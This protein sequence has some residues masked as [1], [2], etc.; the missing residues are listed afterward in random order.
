MP[1]AWPGLEC[2]LANA[3]RLCVVASQGVHRQLLGLVTSRCSSRRR[4]KRWPHRL[5][6]LKGVSRTQSR[7]QI[8]PRPRGKTKKKKRAA[9]TPC[10][11]TSARRPTPT[12]GSRTTGASMCRLAP[13]C[14]PTIAGPGWTE[15]GSPQRFLHCR[16]WAPSSELLPE[17]H[18]ALPAA[19]CITHCCSLTRCSIRLCAL[20]S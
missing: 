13:R 17:T 11:H 19:A 15:H 4:T 7:R 9:A 18:R 16:A 6:G 14:C 5:R 1:P 10:I 3:C 8:L 20:A 12:A 2:V